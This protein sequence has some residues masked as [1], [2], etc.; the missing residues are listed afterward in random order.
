MTTTK[1]PAFLPLLAAIA[2]SCG[3]VTTL[4]VDAP[5][6]KGGGGSTGSGGT[7]SAGSSGSGGG[8]ATGSGGNGSGGNVGSGGAGGSGVAGHSGSGGSSGMGGAGGQGGTG[9]SGV[10]NVACMVGRV[11]C[12]GACVNAD[13]DPMNCGKCG[14]QCDGTN[15]FCSNGKCMQPPCSS[16]ATSCASNS[17]CCGGGCCLPGQLC[18]ETEGPLSGGPPTC[19]TPTATEKTCPQGC[20]PLC[21]SDR[22]QKKN[23]APVDARAV[24]EKV[25]RLPISTWRDRKSVV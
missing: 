2:L 20:A 14:V 10:C 6:D 8:G 23:I 18:C 1:T 25:S 17:F 15:N 4:S 7:G 9:G 21:V 11:C 12:G 13:N 24:L 22:N 3:S 19:F 16:T 5:T